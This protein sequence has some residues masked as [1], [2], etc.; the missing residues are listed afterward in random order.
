MG[1]MILSIILGGVSGLISFSSKMFNQ[2]VDLR[3]AQTNLTAQAYKSNV[4]TTET[5]A[6]YEVDD[7]GNDIGTSAVKYT[8]ETGTVKEL[9]YIANTYTATTTY[10]GTDLDGV[11]VK[12]FVTE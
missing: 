10:L 9:K 8:D 2:S 5:I 6:I 12:L 7:D 4:G 3:R 1:F 11:E